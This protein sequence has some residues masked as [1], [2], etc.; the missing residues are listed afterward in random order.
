MTTSR[1]AARADDESSED[2]GVDEE[3]SDDSC[4]VE[5]LV[6]GVGEKVGVTTLLIILCLAVTTICPES[7][8]FVVTMKSPF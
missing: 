8:S 2:D 5:S 6:G 1:K 3:S 4:V 7:Q